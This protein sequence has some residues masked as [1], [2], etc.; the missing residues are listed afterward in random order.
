MNYRKRGKISPY[1]IRR[2]PRL[3]RIQENA[4]IKSPQLR[5]MSVKELAA[6]VTILKHGRGIGFYPE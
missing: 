1:I 2:P 3:I 5:Y 4:P 6:D